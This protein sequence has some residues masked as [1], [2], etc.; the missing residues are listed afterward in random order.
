L[1][2]F[3]AAF[4]ALLP[5]ALKIPLYR[6][7]FH[8][9]IGKN[10]KIGFSLFI[11]VKQCIIG[12]DVRIGHLNLFYQIE[13]LELGEHIQIGFF[14]L[15]RGGQSIRIGSYSTILRQNTFNSILERD[16]LEPAD[17]VLEFG[18]GVF[19]AAGHWLDFSHR[20]TIGDHTILG[21]RNSSFWTHNRQRARPISIGAHC[22]LGSEIRVAPGVTLPRFTIVALGAVLSGDIDESRML[23][24]GNPAQVVRPLNPRDLYLIA[25]KTRN[26]IPD[27]IAYAD[28]PSD[29]QDALAHEQ[30]YLPNGKEAELAL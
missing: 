7:L 2:F 22:Y 10:V 26:D 30:N 12:D 23:V 9:R 11:G 4:L 1:K 6:W 28:I 25:R 20:I 16:F 27:V 21:G 13:N 18:K 19:V 15:L 24:G 5:S 17:A 14:N 29:I 8:Y 3:F